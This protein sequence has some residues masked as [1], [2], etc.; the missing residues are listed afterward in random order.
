MTPIAWAMLRG[1]IALLALIYLVVRLVQAL[2]RGVISSPIGQVSR[3]NTPG[4]YWVMIGWRVLVI[5]F[6]LWIVPI[7]VLGLQFTGGI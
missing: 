2:M 4:G 5:A 7:I 3:Y 1:I 6:I